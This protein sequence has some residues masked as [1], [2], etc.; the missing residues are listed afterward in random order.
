MEQLDTLIREGAPEGAIQVRCGLVGSGT[1]SPSLDIMIAQAME[2]CHA[3]LFEVSVIGFAALP[4]RG[5][6]SRRGGVDS[7]ACLACS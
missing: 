3:M 7:V 5:N 2:Q 4:R 1:G 6:R